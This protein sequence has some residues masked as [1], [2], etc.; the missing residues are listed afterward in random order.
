MPEYLMNEESVDNAVQRMGA[1]GEVM[2]STQ[3]EVNRICATIEGNVTDALAQEAPLL[4]ALADLDAASAD[5]MA[6]VDGAEVTGRSWETVRGANTDMD[7]SVRGSTES[8]ELV[9]QNFRTSC[10][11]L[12][13]E[14]ALH[15]TDFERYLGETRVLNDDFMAK[16]D[17][18]KA[19]VAATFDQGLTAG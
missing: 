13:E 7:T 9:F 1:R 18:W 5:A 14:L 19:D 4:A 11:A 15:R 10:N 2:T 8:M 12:L 3:A 17:A 6:A 16:T